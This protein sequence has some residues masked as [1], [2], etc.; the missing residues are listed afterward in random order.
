MDKVLK[1][2]SEV[3][4]IKDERIKKAACEMIKLLPDYFFVVPAGG[5]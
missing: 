5:D 4:Y 1:F 3:A 2:K